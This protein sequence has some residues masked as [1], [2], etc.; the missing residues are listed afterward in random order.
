VAAAVEQW[1]E[2]FRTGSHPRS[3]GMKYLS[4]DESAA[5]LL[6]C[7]LHG[8]RCGAWKSGSS[9]TLRYW[10]NDARL[11]S[12]VGLRRAL[13]IHSTGKAGLLLKGPAPRL[14]CGRYRISV[15]GSAR[16]VTGDENLSVRWKASR[17]PLLQMGMNGARHGNWTVEG[18]F[19]LE[20]DS[21]E[22]EFSF[23]VAERSDLSI[24]AVRIQRI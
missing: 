16:A 5:Q 22:V 12:L 20:Q 17:K 9:G 1:L 14:S 2:W 24:S 15:A 11:H 3:N 23:R 21:D 6:D 10:G 8:A 4:W 18:E 19:S 13:A 7:V